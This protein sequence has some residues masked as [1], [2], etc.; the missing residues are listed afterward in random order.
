MWAHKYDTTRFLDFKMKVTERG[1]IF[2]KGEKE[3]VKE[4]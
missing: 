3:R 1:I 4:G 2:K